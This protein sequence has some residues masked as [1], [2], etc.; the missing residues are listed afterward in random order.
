[1]TQTLVFIDWKHEQ[2]LSAPFYVT[3]FKYVKRNVRGLW[4]L[5]LQKLL[6]V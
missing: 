4:P 1:M 6:P 2:T 3:K 5:M